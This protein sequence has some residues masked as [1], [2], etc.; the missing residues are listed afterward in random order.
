MPYLIAKILKSF[1]YAIA[2]IISGCTERNM[3]VHCVATVLVVF[4][5]FLF[6]ISQSEWLWVLLMIGLVLAAEL[7]NTAVEEMCNSMR[8]ELGL[9]YASSKR[10]RDLAAGAVLVLA[11]LAAVSGYIIFMPKVWL[12]FGMIIK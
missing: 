1:T 11:I 5:G 3:R 8:D 7:M 6:Q 10:P 4:L 9:P 12:M 2:G